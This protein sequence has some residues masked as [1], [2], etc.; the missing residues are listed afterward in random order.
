[1]KQLTL[2]SFNPKRSSNDRDE[3]SSSTEEEYWRMFA[4]NPLQAWAP[5]KRNTF[6][7]SWLSQFDLL[8][9]DKERGTSIQCFIL[10]K[11][12]INMGVQSSCTPISLFVP[13]T[14]PVKGYKKTQSKISVDTLIQLLLNIEKSGER[15]EEWL[16]N[17]LP[18]H[19]RVGSVL[20]PSKT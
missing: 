17:T 2:A 16:V 4:I 14:L 12:L 19:T 11:V 1:M 6:P 20:H 9:F 18:E 3:P 15:S 5:K 10:M 13:P 7:S 8:G